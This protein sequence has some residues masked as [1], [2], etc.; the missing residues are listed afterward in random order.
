MKKERIKLV[1][2]VDLTRH[3]RG[4]FHEPQD[5]VD[6]LTRLLKDVCPHY[7]PSIRLYDEKDE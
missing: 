1:V 7:N 3:E 2:E 5:W 4:M 6:Y